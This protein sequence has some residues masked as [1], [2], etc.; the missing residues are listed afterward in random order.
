MPSKKP[1]ATA[2]DQLKSL[3]KAY[4]L[5]RLERSTEERPTKPAQLGPKKPK[6]SV[7]RPTIKSPP[8]RGSRNDAKLAI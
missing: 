1:Q 8:N 6:A 7:G 4:A 5:R 3:I 2:T